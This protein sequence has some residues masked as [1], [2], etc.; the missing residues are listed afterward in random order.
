MNIILYSC[1]EDVLLRWKEIISAQYSSV[2]SY[3]NST[4]LDNLLTLRAE[5]SILLYQ[6]S[7]IEDEEEWLKNFQQRHH[8]YLFIIALSNSPDPQKGVRL[9]DIGV[10]GFANTFSSG[11][12]LL[13]AID[14]VNKGEVW[15]GDA[16]IKFI[17]AY[18][19]RQISTAE[20]DE[21][22]DDSSANI[23]FKK[24]TSR[25]QQIAQKVLLGKQ[26][27]IIADELNI[28]ERT[29]KTHLSAIYK[30]AEVRN[31]LELS[32]ALQKIDRRSNKKRVDRR[33]A[34]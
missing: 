24:L 32:L 25:E 16:L 1:N 14:V 18:L 4:E 20:L 19:K 23:I 27:K 8:E 31:R 26:N 15:L 6:L 11:E 5:K 3:N 9:L 13:M 29:V 10:K 17:L 12:K 7:G 2:E 33:R 21:Q 30:K 22:N 34:V 28:T